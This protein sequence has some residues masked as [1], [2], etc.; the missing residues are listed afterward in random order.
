MFHKQM[1]KLEANA[2]DFHLK[3]LTAIKS[4]RCNKECPL[5]NEVQAHW[6]DTYHDFLFIIIQKG[7]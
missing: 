7:W 1:Y 4:Y 6:V 3:V 5:P 2:T